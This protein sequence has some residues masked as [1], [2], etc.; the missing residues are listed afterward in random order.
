MD[1]EINK[2]CPRVNAAPNR[3]RTSQQRVKINAAAFNQGN[4]VS[5]HPNILFVYLGTHHFLNCIVLKA[6][7]YASKGA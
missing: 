2:H 4:T 5:A 3:R 7:L 6:D 1:S